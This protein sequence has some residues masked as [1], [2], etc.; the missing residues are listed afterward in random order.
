MGCDDESGGGADVRR[1]IL[2]ASSF[3]LLHDAR[4][5]LRPFTEP[6]HL[7]ERRCHEPTHELRFDLL[8]SDL[9]IVLVSGNI[10]EDLRR[11][12]AE[13]G[14]A[15]ILGKPFKARELSDLIANLPL[16]ARTSRA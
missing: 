14:I 7:R 3:G 16:Q 4:L 5:Q 6:E 1:H 9:P 12:A 10:N 11:A 15:A 2:S 8:H 13:V